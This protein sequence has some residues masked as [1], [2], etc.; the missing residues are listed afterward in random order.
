MCLGLGLTQ[1]RAFLPSLLFGSVLLLA[2]GSGY[3]L[4]GLGLLWLLLPALP[5]RHRLT[6][7]PTDG[8]PV[9]DDL[10]ARGGGRVWGGRRTWLVV[11][12]GTSQPVVC[13]DDLD[14]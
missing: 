14:R 12:A 8:D 13:D 6:N 2:A 7:Q 5:N 9:G 10:E 11:R 4:A 3:Q 1:L